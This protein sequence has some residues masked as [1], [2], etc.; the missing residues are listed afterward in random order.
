MR[1]AF[2]A[3]GPAKAGHYRRHARRHS[4]K[5]VASAFRRI[6]AAVILFTAPAYAQT[7]PVMEAVTLEQAIE[8]AIKN[9]PTVA[10]AAEGILRAEGLLQQAR[11]AA[12][13]F[14]TANLVGVQ[15]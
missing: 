1:S 6:M 14:I 3:S 2:F 15:N 11:A 9:N 4:P 8:R 12:M 13:P 5:S 7:P 10:Q